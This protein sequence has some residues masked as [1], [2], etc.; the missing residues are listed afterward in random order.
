MTNVLTE[1]L[2]I[3]PGPLRNSRRFHR[4]AN[5][6]FRY[7]AKRSTDIGIV[8][9]DDKFKPNDSLV[10][11]TAQFRF[12]YNIGKII[13]KRPKQLLED[14]NCNYPALLIAK[15][16]SDCNVRHLFIGQSLNPWFVAAAL[17]VAQH[18]IL[19]EQLIHIDENN[20]TENGI[21]RFTI[22]QMGV[23]HKVVVDDRLPTL[24]SE[25]LFTKPLFWSCCGC[26]WWLP[27]LEKAYAK[28]FGS[29]EAMLT[30]GSIYSALIDLSGGGTIYKVDINLHLEDIWLIIYKEFQSKS[31]LL[32]KTK[33]RIC[34]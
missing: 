22:W 34:F 26:S 29:Y 21:A 16:N 3:E 18:Q 9:S 10:Y 12:R 8:F 24:N 19:L 11:K 6:S 23:L 15:N 25:P 13:W 28:I 1:S 5:Q 17:A 14:N 7:L 32:L 20:F 33:V 27:L 4:Y 2:K 30:N 31:L